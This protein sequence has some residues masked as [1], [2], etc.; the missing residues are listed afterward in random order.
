[1]KSQPNIS[2]ISCSFNMAALFKPLGRAFVSFVKSIER[3]YSLK[4]GIL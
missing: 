3:F 4:L 1:M 2:N